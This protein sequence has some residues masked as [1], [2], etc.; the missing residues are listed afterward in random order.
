M[1]ERILIADD[2]PDVAGAVEI[3][4]LLEGYEVDV[5]HDGVAALEL[6]RA[7]QPDLVLLDV[8]MPRLDGYDV[9]RELRA[10]PR[11]LNT[12]VIL[13]TAKS[14]SG[15]K[16][17]G[18][19]AG[20]D[21]F[22]VKP[23]EPAELIARVRSV[24]RRANQMRD[25]SPLTRLPGNLRIAAELE[26]LVVQP[27]AEF[28]VLYADLNDF[29]AFN[30]HYGFLRGDELLKFTAKLIT[31][32]LA[33][34]PSTPNFAGHVGG[35]DFVMIVAPAVAENVCRTIIDRFD[36]GVLAFYDDEDRA[37]GFIETEDRRGERHR[38]APVSIAIG[39]AT[40][41]RREIRSQWEASVISSEMKSHAKRHGRSAYEVDRREA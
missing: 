26:T 40:T 6:A 23:F 14:L 30:D 13:L 28:A 20:A 15:D 22:I 11:T 39:V 21:D 2:D 8:V 25:L 19:A 31:D 29:K 41:D 27:E 33:A 35:D 17:H 5:V 24:L 9:C 1:G 18:F 38:H 32:A 34:H 12:A 37:R 10:D 3:N 36:E 16:L 7:T 4:L